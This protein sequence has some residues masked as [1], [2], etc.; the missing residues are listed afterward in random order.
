MPDY[1]IRP[2]RFKEIR[3]QLLTRLI[4][5][6]FLTGVASVTMTIYTSKDKVDYVIFLPILIVLLIAVFVFSIYRAVK[7]Q[8][9]LL[10]NYALTINENTVTRYQLNTPT[11]SLYHNEIKEI[12]KTKNGSFIIKGKDAEDIILVPAQIDNYTDLET[13]LSQIKPV[14]FQKSKPVYEKYPFLNIILLIGLMAGVYVSM[15]KIIVLACGT[16]LTIIM[17]WSFYKV[18]KSKNVE[19]RTKQ[20]SWWSLIVLVSIICVTILKL[21]G[22]YHPG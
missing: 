1:K 2:D 18:Q 20:I 8:K 11:I 6:F 3:N 13:L 22:H 17:V 4:I 15:N 16:L 5:L 12:L 9:K 19:N 21:I 7:K 14:I 10:D